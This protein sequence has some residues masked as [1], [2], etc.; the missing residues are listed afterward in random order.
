VT[1]YTAA[2]YRRVFDDKHGQGSHHVVVAMPEVRAPVRAPLPLAVLL[3]LPLL[4]TPAWAGSTERVS[5]SSTGVQ[6]NGGS[7]LPA[8]SADGRYVAFESDATNLVP[9]DTNEV[10]DIFVR[11]RV[12]GTTE[13][14]SVSTT[15][16][17][18]NGYCDVPSI[19]ADGRFVVFVSGASTLVPGHPNPVSNVFVH[20]RKTGTTTQ[21]SVSSNG[22]QGNGDSDLYGASISANDRYVAFTSRANNLVRGDTNGV[23]DVFVRD[24]QTGT[25]ARVSMSSGGAQSNGE[26]V[27]GGISSNGR[28]LAFWS[29]AS[30]LVRGDTNGA[31]DVFVRDRRANTTARVSVS[32]RGVQGDGHSGAGWITGDGRYVAFVSRA[33][34]LVP[35]DRNSTADVF[36]RDRAAGI[37][38][39][40]SVSSSGTEGNAGSY[41]PWPNVRAI[42]Q[43]GRF[44]VFQSDAGNL[45]PNDVNGY[46][47]VFVRDR[48][49][50]ATELISISVDGHPANGP[51]FFSGDLG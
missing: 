16:V 12:A 26:S 51:S 6:A 9:D 22:V 37:T 39:R 2:L 25:T 18:S 4:A 42:T 27:V 41:E 35:G 24:L 20:D 17:Q 30:N 47:D 28:F 48:T 46:A 8:I 21:A 7:T 14:V 11:D 13:R 49:A 45:V 33:T 44:M 29:S 43:D 10:R 34:N 23:G 19:S 50:G 3:A 32:S 1:T 40:A 15:G 36:V 38:Q 5:V 31:E